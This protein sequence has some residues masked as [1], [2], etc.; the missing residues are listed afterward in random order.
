[1]KAK[2]KL[3]TFTFAV[4]IA[5]AGLLIWALVGAWIW[6][7]VFGVLGAGSIALKL[8]IRAWRRNA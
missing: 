5:S 3:I 6:A 8:A 7:I 1:M 4:T 2:T